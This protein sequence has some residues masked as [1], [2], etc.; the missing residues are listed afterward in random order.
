MQSVIKVNYF[1]KIVVLFK[2]VDNIHLYILH[3]KLL[4]VEIA[5]WLQDPE[6]ISP[7][8]L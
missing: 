7:Q 3:S 5:C 4:K 2:T 1:R 8:D 6:E